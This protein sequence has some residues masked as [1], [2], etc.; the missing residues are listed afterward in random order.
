MD[1]NLI[2]LFCL[3]GTAIAQNLTDE[4]PLVTAPIGKIR[5]SILT[6]RLGKKIYSF[7]GVRYGEPPTGHQRFQVRIVVIAIHFCAIVNLSYA[8]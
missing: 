7:R 6:S 8:F 2:L 4:K 1:N 5:G 3:L